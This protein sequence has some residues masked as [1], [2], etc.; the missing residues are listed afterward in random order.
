[1]IRL[2]YH[3]RQA[4]AS[5]NPPLQKKALSAIIMVMNVRAC[6]KIAFRQV[7]GTVCGGFGLNEFSDTL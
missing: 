3:Q 6:L 7:C 5:R 4:F 1:L 2:F